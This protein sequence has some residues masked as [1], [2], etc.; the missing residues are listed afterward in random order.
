MAS[1]KSKTSS[2]PSLGAAL[3]QLDSE[4]EQLVLEALMTIRKKFIKV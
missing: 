1:G 3:E 4:S 2:I